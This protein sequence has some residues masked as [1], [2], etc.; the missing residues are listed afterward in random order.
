[1]F[2]AGSAVAVVAGCSVGSL[3]VDDGTAVSTTQSSSVVVTSLPVSTHSVG[4]ELRF[5]DEVATAT[6]VGSPAARQ[7]AALL[8]LELDLRDPMG[9]AKSGRLPGPLDVTGVEP[10]VDPAVGHIYY[11]APSVLEG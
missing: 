4:I 5:G 6:L 7:F 10:V 1:M 11:W 3:A 2:A 8:P 9:Q